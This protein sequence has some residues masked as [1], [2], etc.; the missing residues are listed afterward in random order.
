VNFVWDERKN[1]ANVRKHGIELAF[2]RELF[3]TRTIEF[4]DKRK[5]YGEARFVC[6]GLIGYRVYCCVYTYR[7][8]DRRIISLR[9][10]NKEESYDYFTKVG[11]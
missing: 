4:E 8:G 3:E 5:D 2:A 7:N 1:K 10:A 9:K 11:T 6:Y